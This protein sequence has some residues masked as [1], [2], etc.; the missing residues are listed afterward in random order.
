MP[1]G[2]T[3]S[4]KSFNVTECTF[5]DTVPGAH[6][7]IGTNNKSGDTNPD[8]VNTTG[9]FESV[10]IANNATSVKVSTP[11]DGKTYTVAVGQ[12]FTKTGSGDPVIA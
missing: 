9:A 8:A 4:V 5:K 1:K 7:M 10:S 11:Y 2:V 3:T 6:V 12:A